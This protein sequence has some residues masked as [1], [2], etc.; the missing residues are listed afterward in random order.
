MKRSELPTQYLS[1]EN[2]PDLMLAAAAAPILYAMREKRRADVAEQREFL[3]LLHSC[4][5]F[6][7][8]YY[9]ERRADT[10]GEGRPQGDR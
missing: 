7:L 4:F 5:S 3:D 2:D 9:L 10:A 8:H 1:R 6:A